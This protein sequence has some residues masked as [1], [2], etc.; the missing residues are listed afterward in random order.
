MTL[1]ND[2]IMAVRIAGRDMR[3]D[4]RALWLLVA[5]V[6]IGT[7]AV[8]LVG[9]TS[10]G[11]AESARQSALETVGGDL[12]LRLFHRPP[13]ETELAIIRREGDI[14]VTTELRP[15][16]RAVTNGQASGTPV[17]VELKGVD[18]GYPLVGSVEILPKLNLYQTLARHNG[19]YGA[20]AD[21]A[22]FDAMSLT[23]GDRVQIGDTQYQL[24]ATLLVEPDRAFR[25]FTLGP[26]IIVSDESLQA[27]GVA[28]IGAEVYFY[29]RVSLPIEPDMPAAASAALSRIDKASPQ[30]GWRMVNAHDGVPGVE[31]TLALAHALLL[32]IGLGVMLVGG[33]GIVSAV[34]AHISEK[35]KTIAILKSV[36]TPPHVVTLAI[37]LEVMSTASFGAV[38]G[39]CLGAFGP[40][41]AAF[42][43]ADQLPFALESN[44]GVKPLVAAALFGILVALLFSW[45]PLMGIRNTNAQVLLRDHIAYTRKELGTCG[46]IGVGIILTA[47]ATLVFWTSPMPAFTGVFLIGALALAVFYYALGA[48]LVCMTRFLA[49]GKGINVRFALSNIY[50]AGAPTSSVVMALGL[51]LTLLVALDGIGV[52]ARLHVQE[53]LP[54]S[55]PDLVAF[56]LKPEV[57]ERLEIELSDTGTVEYQRTLP[58]LHARVQSIGGVPVSDLETPASMNWVIRGDRGVSFA[59]ILPDGSGWN[60]S[61]PE[62]FGFSVA[63]DVAE[64]LGLAPGDTMTL[65]VSGHVRSG[66]VLRF[67]DVDWNGLN[68]DFPIIATPATFKGVPYTFAASLKAV[69]YERDALESLVR[70]RFPDA[71]LIRVADVLQSFTGFLDALIAG[72]ETATLVCGLA[73][74]VVLAGSVLQGLRDRINEAV[75]LKVLGARRNQLLGLLVAEFLGLG[76]LVA[77]TAVPLGFSVA[78][79]ATVS[80]GLGN[81][82]MLWTGGIMWAAVTISVTLVVG[83]TATLG[84]YTAKPARNL[85]NARL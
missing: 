82:G 73:A 20:V 65:N 57:A 6:F 11:I 52:A 4:L 41:L 39:V 71:P 46:W 24:R 21:S 1:F 77:L 54:R 60:T 58:F 25:A 13:S 80:V 7:A 32:F 14:S 56:S 19:V 2:I 28:D 23:P 5:G 37:G 36:G 34:R 61:Q 45:W 53:T 16:A 18:Q 44:P 79:G 30:S 8:A 49:K 33:A 9:A 62:Q 17:L 76:A 51:T 42:V 35:T 10:H 78:Y 67:H 3:G 63:T 64:K 72:L 43:L 83:I 85:R 22:F 40:T 26:R 38:L 70:Q 68:L 75:L 29:T 12:S 55:A 50:R 27:A 66:P 47:L 81:A 59:A 31:R 74:L 84:V 48:G 69:P 15:M